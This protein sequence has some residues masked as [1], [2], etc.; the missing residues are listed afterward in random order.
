MIFVWHWIEMGLE[1]YTVLAAWFRIKYPHIAIGAVAASAP[2]LQFEDI[3]PTDTFYRIVSSDF[4]RESTSC[5]NYIRE[6]WDAIDN[7]AAQNGGLHNL[8]T[9]FHMCRDLQGA[10]ELEDWLS[11]AYSYLAM[12]DYPFASDFLM[13]LPAYPIREVCQAI[14]GLPDGS[15]VLSRIF[16]GASVYYNYTGNV[17]CFQ[18][19]DSGN[20]DL[21]TSGWNWQACTEMVMPMSSDPDNSMFQPFSWDLKSYDQFCMENYGVK[22]RPYWITSEYGGKNIKAVLKNSASNIVFSNGL[23]DPWSGGGVLED[24]SSSIVALV[25]P[26]GAHHLDLRAATESDPNWLVQQRAMEIR[27]ISKWLAE[28]YRDKKQTTKVSKVSNSWGFL[29]VMTVAILALIVIIKVDKYLVFGRVPR[30]YA[31]LQ[32]A[33]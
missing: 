11:S 3:V 24:I 13:P 31:P 18:P 2:I 19:D 10:W 23:L 32:S 21:G 7:I 14:D 25:V 8:S 15:H 33:Q 16:A 28:V 22:P 4:K 30:L 29:I 12:V 5:F 1:M 20:I 9:K 17:D 27:Y 26:E 6:S